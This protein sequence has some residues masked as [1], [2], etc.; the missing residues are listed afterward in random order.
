M[1]VNS[2]LSLSDEL[3]QSLDSSN[4]DLSF[5]ER[6]EE[7]NNKKQNKTLKKR[8]ISKIS[9]QM[10]ELKQKIKTI[11]EFDD[12][13]T[14]ENDFYLDEN[15]RC[16]KSSLKS[17]ES[18]AK[19][20]NVFNKFDIFF[21]FKFNQK[22]FIIS[23]ESDVF[24]LNQNNIEDLVKNTIKKINEKNIFF[25]DNKINYILSLKDCEEDS[26]EDFYKDNYELI[27]YSKK[28]INYPFDLLLNEVKNQKINLICK[29][30]LNIMIRQF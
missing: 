21:S 7:F 18:N 10:E 30:T 28:I 20:E 2:S 4:M 14:D 17:N 25:Q 26:N 5:N 11:K 13:S 22:D 9:L 29:N 27:S 12:Y 1:S 24:N 8:K 15:S 23:L 6:E 19:K 16:S 3:N